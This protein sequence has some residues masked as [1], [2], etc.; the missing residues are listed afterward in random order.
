M[1]SDGGL[2]PMESFI[3]SRAILSGPAGGLVGYATTSPTTAPVIGFDM[4]GTS[5]DVSRYYRELEHVFE[6]TSAAGIPVQIPQ[7]DIQ[8]VAA[9]GGS[10]LFFRSGLFVVGPESAGALPGPRCYRNQGPLTITDCN[11]VLGRII[12]EYFPAIFGPNKDQPLDEEGTREAFALLT[13]EI[14]KF[15]KDNNIPKVLSIEEVALGFINVADETMCRPIRAVTQARGY[16]TQDHILACFGGAGGQHAC[17]VAR[18]LGISSVYTHRYA[19]ILSAFGM[20]CADVVHEE[21][22]PCGKPY[23]PDEFDYFVDRLVSLSQKS[24]AHFTSQGYPLSTIRLMPYLHMRFQGTEGSLMCGPQVRVDPGKHADLGALFKTDLVPQVKAIFLERY[25]E[26]YGFV[27]NK[28]IV[29]DDVRVRGL[30]TLETSTQ[31]RDKSLTL[32]SVGVRSPPVKKVSSTYFQHNGQCQAMSTNIYDYSSLQQGDKI[33]GPA[34]I[35]NELS[36]ILVEPNCEAI[37]NVTGDIEIA[38]DISSTSC[39]IDTHLD[40]IQ[41]SIFSH[42]F[43]S[44]AEQMGRVLQRTAHSTNIKERLDFSCALF[45]PDGGLV[46]NAPHIPVHL[47]SMQ[48]AVKFQEYHLINNF[49]EEEFKSQ[50]RAVLSRGITSVAIVL[51]HSYA[52]HD[53]E[54]L[55]GRIARDLGFAHVSLSHEV[56]PMVK[57]VARGN[58]TVIDAYLTPHIKQYLTVPGLILHSYEIEEASLHIL[59]TLSSGTS[60]STIIRAINNFTVQITELYDD[61]RVRGLA[62]LETSTQPREKS[63]TLESVGVRSPPVKKVSSTYFQHNGQCQAMSTNIYDYSS[64]QQGDK[65]VGPA[66]IMNELSTILVE[67]N[68]EATINVTGDIEIAV[69]ISSTSCHID[70]H[71]DPIQLSI[72][73]QPLALL[74]LKNLEPKILSCYLSV[75]LDIQTVAAG[76]GSMLFFRSGLFVVGPES[77]GALPG[78]RCYRNQGPLTITDC[79]LVLGR[80]IP[81]YF[82]AIFGPNKD[83]P[84]DEEGTREAFALL[85]KEARGYDTQD[86]ILACF[87]GAG[88][89]H[90]CSVAR[91]LGI[92]SVYTHRY[93]GIL[94]AFGMACAD[95]VHEEQE[96]CGK[97]YS[98]DEFDYF[99]DRLVALSQKSIAHF[100]SQGYPLATIRLM[101]YLHMRFQGTEGSL[102]CGPQVRVDPGKHADLG[103]LFRTDLVPQVKAI[104]LE[105]YK[106][107]YGFVLNKPIVVDDVRV[108]G[109][110]TLETSTQPRDKSLTLES[111]GVRSPP[112]KK[113]SSTYFQHNGQC[114]AMST[115]IYDY[116]SLQQGDKIVGP[117]IIMNE[118]STIL[119]EPNCEA[120]INVTGDIE[121]AVDI[122]STSCHIDTHLDPIQLSIFSHRFMSIAEQMGSCSTEIAVDIS[123]TSCHIDTHLDPIQLSIFS[124]RFMSIAEQMGRVLQ[125]TA[126]ST[127]IKERLDFSCALFGPDGGL[128]SNAPHIPVHLGSMQEAVKFQIDHRKGNFKKGSVILSNHP[129]AGG[130][131]LPDLTVITPVFIDSQPVEEGPVF[132]VANR[133][134]HADI[135]GLTPGSMPPHSQKLTEEGAVFESFDIVRDG[136]FQEA[137]V[138]AQLMEPAK[139]PGCSGTRNLPDNLADLKAQIAANQKGI[140]LVQDVIQLYGL[141]VVQA[142]MKHIQTNAEHSVRDLLKQ[143]ALK[144]KGESLVAEDFMDDGSRIA[145]IVTIDAQTGSAVFDFSFSERQVMGNCNAP[146]SITKSAVM[147]CLRC[148]VGYDIPLNQGCLTPIQIKLTPGSILNPNDNVAVVGGNVQTS[149]RVVDVILKAFGVAASSQGCMNNITFGDQTWGYY[150]TVGGGAGAGP[151]WHGRSGVHSHM[152]NTRITDA[153]ILETR[154]PIMLARFGLREG[155]AGLGKYSGGSGMIRE[156]VFRKPMTLCMLTERRVFWPQGLQGGSPG[157]RGMNLLVSS[158]EGGLQSR[159]ASKSSVQ[160]QSGDIFCLYTPGGGGYGT[161]TEVH[162]GRPL[163]DPTEVKNKYQRVLLTS[164]EGRKDMETLLNF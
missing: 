105:R 93:A 25:K 134:H 81:E 132:F 79:N 104:F 137:A 57:I 138:T 143:V 78:P 147:Y 38:V 95:V 127:N 72:F 115:N 157:A 154:Y 131:H 42:R 96:P 76:G 136:E 160:V 69:D 4:G 145:L 19:G 2:T 68:C 139:Y 21:Q 150:E 114:Q 91:S 103:A 129:K 153:E 113:V 80:I 1:Q 28:P 158:S 49:N 124:H 63:L 148:M 119:V 161:P 102:M 75:Q 144:Y 122:S 162:N 50:L 27:L 41:L 11:L 14:N 37:I 97:P 155:S 40:P 64:L 84:L 108:R 100:T 23:S 101:P 26:E 52:V 85:T 140:S 36:T 51:M 22:E 135:G 89:Q 146:K 164:E 33:V 149:Q 55:L 46:S 73:H 112:V 56:M 110:A 12:P 35:M 88:G 8:T 82:P 32:E 62:T 111:V 48:E 151:Y 142:Y 43:M 58:T 20:A 16:D 29:V 47:G 98:P 121:I 99:V 5:T 123:S 10:M 92:S 106:E 159:L 44:I 18:S 90:A 53:Q 130:S 107:E 59:A 24:I 125:R 87:G 61:V 109:L 71:L 117:A 94:S 39:H 9:G 163:E 141:P 34:I 15:Y 86:H 54:L 30:A 152:T 116:S 133:G 7:L 3:G 83:Q 74:P 120:I 118:L 70:T 6:S 31:P 65:I 156:Y 17:S 128:V 77:A 60:G 13:K 45:G 126:H 67:P 66:I